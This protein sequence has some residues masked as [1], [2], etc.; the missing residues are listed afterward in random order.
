MANRLLR[1]MEAL[2]N[3]VVKLYGSFVTSTSGTVA[4]TSAKGFT[5][6]KTAAETGRY[7]LTLADSWTALLACSVALRGTTDAAYTSAKG[8]TWFLRN[9]SVTTAKTLDIQFCDPDGSPADA[10]LEDA[11]AVYIELTLKNTSA[12]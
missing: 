1:K 11:A 9:V 7:T 8:L 5:I 10:E 3:G 6:A 12:Y 4:S 2:E